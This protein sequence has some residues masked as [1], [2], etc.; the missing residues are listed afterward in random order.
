[1]LAQARAQGQGEDAVV[2]VAIP[3]LA[4]D[5]EQLGLL[6]VGERSGRAAEGGGPTL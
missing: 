1:V 2:P 4:G 6:D 5:L 3:M